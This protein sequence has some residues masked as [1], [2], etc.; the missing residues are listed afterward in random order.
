VLDEDI[1]KA[2]RTGTAGRRRAFEHS[3]EQHAAG[4]TYPSRS[5]LR[6]RLPGP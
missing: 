3:D 1:I 6:P 5:S 4:S 2:L